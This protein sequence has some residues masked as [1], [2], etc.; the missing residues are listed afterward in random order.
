MPGTL[1]PRSWAAR[2]VAN[3]RRVRG[4][5]SMLTM[6]TSGNGSVLM[7]A[8][9][10]VGE[11]GVYK[12][13]V[14]A[15]DDAGDWTHQQLS[16]GGSSLTTT[17]EG[18]YR[19]RPC[20]APRK[21]P[22]RV[23]PPS[24]SSSGTGTPPPLLPSISPQLS[25]QQPP[26]GGLVNHY[27]NIAHAL[28]DK[29]LSEKS[30][31]TAPP[32]AT[33]HRAPACSATPDAKQRVWQPPATTPELPPWLAAAPELPPAAVHLGAAPA[34]PPPSPPTVATPPPLPLEDDDEWQRERDAAADS[35][36]LPC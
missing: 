9:Q 34:D 11:K 6:S 8:C 18:D 23:A 21:T 14:D 22:P 28:S 29:A 13:L 20:T 5:H 25:T 30:N 27:T 3:N 32:E 36:S 31:G 4:V 26:A 2:V 16:K 7:R 12:A 17:W 15:V 33:L 1:H 10:V 24:V 35:P 19:P